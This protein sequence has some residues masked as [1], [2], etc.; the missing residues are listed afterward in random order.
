MKEREAQVSFEKDDGSIQGDRHW[1]KVD[2]GVYS[3]RGEKILKCM[4][5]ISYFVNFFVTCAK[6]ITDL[7]VGKS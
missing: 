6:H 1:Y 7:I 3:E 5:M 4:K 2:R